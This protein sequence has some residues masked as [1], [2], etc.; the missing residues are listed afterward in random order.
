VFKLL[1]T[2]AL[3]GCIRV[4]EK[5]NTIITLWDIVNKDRQFIR[6]VPAGCEFEAMLVDAKII[7][8]T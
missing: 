5:D 1:K 6:L 3:I 8:S 4:W 2:S 7:T